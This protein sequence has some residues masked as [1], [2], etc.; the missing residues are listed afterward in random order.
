LI[1]GIIIGYFVFVTPPPTEAIPTKEINMRVFQFGY[2]PSII[3]VTEGTK[4]II[5][6]TEVTANLEPGFAVHTFTIGPPYNINVNLEVG[7]KYTIEFVASY[8]GEFIFE[9]AI[10][11]GSQHAAMKGKL[12]VNPKVAGKIVRAE[13][14]LDIKFVNSTLKVYVK[15]EDLPKEPKKWKIEDYPYLMAVVQREY[16]KGAIKII[17]TKT[18]ED[19]GDIVGVGDKVHVVELHPNK[20]WIYSISRDGYVSKIDTYS[21]QIVRQVRV[22]VDSRGLA[23]SYD[24]KYLLAGNYEPSSAVILDAETLAPLKIILAY[25]IDYDG[26]SIKSRVANVYGINKYKL[27]A[28]NLKEVGETWFIEQKPPFK[29]VKTYKTGRILHELNAL[30][31]DEKYI[32]V[33]SQVDNT[34]TIIDVEKMEIV[35]VIKT[36]KKPHPGQGTPDFKYGL[37]YANSISVANIT[38]ININT[39]ELAGYIWP[40]GI[41]VNAGGGLFSSP[42]PIGNPDVKYIWFDI[43][44]GKH[45][46]TLFIVDRE[47]VAKGKFGSEPVVKVITWKDLGLDK[48]GRI[49]H[50]EYS[51]DGKYVVVSAW[52]HNKIIILDAT[53][54]PEIKIVKVIDATTPTGIFP[55]WRAFIEYLG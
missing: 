47:M 28:I 49:I 13:D 51:Y 25:G 20:R 1:I 9:C 33:T 17:N 16:P 55:F 7:K 37:W 50:P 32:A 22:G 36:P 34:Y 5:H 46:G 26:N 40:S 53:A 29:I 3:N 38:V 43:V 52:D 21:L 31:E 44:F 39:L 23:L 14:Y 41:D 19:L 24:G 27:F 30:A 11:C 8:V 48:P 18:L 45:N 54:L 4:V 12:I 6:I 10:Y 42:I 35:K 15:E 2:D